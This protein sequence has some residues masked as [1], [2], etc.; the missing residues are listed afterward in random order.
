M[1]PPAVWLLIVLFAALGARAGEQELVTIPLSHR[2]AEE[3]AALIKPLLDESETVIPNR[4]MLIVKASPQKIEEILALVKDLDKGQHRLLI[5]VAQG[6][7]LSLEA[8][9]ARAGLQ[10]RIDP[11]YPGDV[12][13]EGRGHV[14][15][16]ESRDLGDE[17]QRVQTLDG[18]AAQIQFG[19][20]IPLPAQSVI[21]YGGSV[22]PGIQYFEASTGFTV[23][24]R[25]TGDQVT[26]EVSPW[27]D[28]ISRESGGRIDTQG[29][30]TTLNAAL[31]EWVE[32]GGQVETR[33]QSE[34]GLF[35]HSYSTRTEANKIFIKVD[36]LDAGRP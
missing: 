17:T 34:S 18:Q 28:R 5:A 27:S 35:A 21:G 6:R 29:A 33:S 1:K 3:M 22:N 4:S 8:L 12:Q 2:L 16:T 26:V 23:T 30:H 7:G 9:N 25:L 24:P 11:R 36:D 14:Y 19:E 13:F 20:Q 15:Q 31:G 10:T 32:I